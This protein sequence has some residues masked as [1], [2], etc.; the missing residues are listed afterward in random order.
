MLRLFPVLCLLIF[1]PIGLA[2]TLA[3]GQMISP[4]QLSD[5]H[6]RPGKIDSATRLVLFSR[7]MKANKLA[8]AAFMDRASDYLGTAG[9]VYLIDVSPM[10]RFVTRTFAIPKMQKY[11]YRIYLDREG[12]DSAAY[13]SQKGRI[14]AIHL[15]G[16]KVT[17]VEYVDSAA[18]LN[19]L[20]E[21]HKP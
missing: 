21:G 17:R 15:E 19:A 7:D 3:E 8:K 12:E 2:A 14:T 9:T 4:L 10:P 5:Q 13:P 18:A 6:G 20:V 1:A 11:G 16:L